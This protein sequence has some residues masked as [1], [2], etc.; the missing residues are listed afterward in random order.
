MRAYFQVTMVR[1][2]IK[3]IHCIQK[4]SQNVTEWLQSEGPIWNPETPHLIQIGRKMMTQQVETLS[5]SGDVNCEPTFSF[6]E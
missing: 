5:C 6:L 4:W 3:L 1:I 2:V